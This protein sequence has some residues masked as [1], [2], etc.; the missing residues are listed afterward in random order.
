MNINI[1]VTA[2]GLGLVFLIYWFFF[3]KRQDS[4]EVKNVYDVKVSGGYNPSVLK[5]KKGQSVVLNL[6]RTDNN[7]CLEEFVLWDF[8]I[9]KYLPL[10]EE[11]KIEF[12][13]DKKGEYAFSCGMNMFHGKVVVV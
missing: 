7:S 12:K 8:K 5:V 4:Q 1:I 9:K 2:A 6:T 3:G 13:P 10:N 11:I